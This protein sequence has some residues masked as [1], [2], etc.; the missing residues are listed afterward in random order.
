MI[1]FFDLKNKQK[2]TNQSNFTKRSAKRH[3]DA[4]FLPNPVSIFDTSENISSSNINIY[5]TWRVFVLRLRARKT[6][7]HENYNTFVNSHK[8]YAV[9]VASIYIVG[10]I[11][12]RTGHS[13]RM[14]VVSWLQ[15]KHLYVLRFNI[16]HRDRVYIE[17]QYSSRR[18]Y[19]PV[20]PDTYI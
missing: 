9:H 19:V 17:L 1:A 3:Y 8:T 13:N 7:T 16:N 20:L 5:N 10:Q 15:R 11:R 6:Y 4:N 14:D 18:R 2:N 12:T